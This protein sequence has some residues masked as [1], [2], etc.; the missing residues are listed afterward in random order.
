[1]IQFVKNIFGT[2]KSTSPADL[3]VLRTDIHSHFIPGIDDGAQTMED[4]LALIR[5]MAARGYKKVITTPHIMS[6]HFR[7]TPEIILGGL[8]KVRN[9]VKDEG[10]DITID[11]AA[12][13][14]LDFELTEKLKTQ[15]LLT[16][17]NNYLLFEISFMNAPDNLFQFSFDLHTNG[18]KPV[19]AHPERYTYWHDKFENYEKLVDKGILLQLNLLSLTGHYSIPTKK[20]AERLCKEGM[21]SFLGSDCHHPGHLAMME[22]VVYERSLHEL[23]ASGKLLNNTL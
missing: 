23:L 20:I 8:E 4:S 3:S 17:G 10:I 18:L 11:A 13:Y 6:D 21:I 7:N 15:K 16:F 19:I 5:G 12:E 1:V 14:Y 9:A 22:R 2:S